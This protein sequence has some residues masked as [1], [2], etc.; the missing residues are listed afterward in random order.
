VAR[1]RSVQ[2]SIFLSVSLLLTGVLLAFS[3]AVYD[4]VS[5]V[6]R[7]RFADTLTSLS[8]SVQANLD[9]KVQAMDRLS[10]SLVYSR[11][12][13]DLYMRHLALPRQ[14]GTVELRIAKLEN[15]EAIIEICDTILGPNQSVPQ[16]NVF[17]LRGEMIGAGY[18][19][20]LIERDVR[21]EPWFP[22]VEAGQGELLMLPPRADPLLEDTSVIVKGKLYVSLIRLFRDDMRS[23]QGVIEVKQYC[24]SL[25]GELDK[26]SSP[27]LSIFVVDASGALLYPYSGIQPGGDEGRL[28]LALAGKQAPSRTVTGRLPGKR[29]TQ[30]IAAALSGETGWTLAI[31]ENAAGLSASMLQY[32]ARIALLAL[33]AIL[34]SL[35]ASY[36]IARRITVP[37]K[38][39][40]VEMDGL[41]LENLD[42]VAEGLPDRSLGEIDSLRLAF[43]GMKQKLNES[44]Q[45]AVSLKAHEKQAQLAALQAQLNPHFIHNMLQTIAIMAEDGEKAAIQELIADL[46]KVLRYASSTEEAQATLGT[47][48]EYAECY[49]AAMRLRFGGSFSY[50]I[51]VD[52]AMRG[53]P[54][55]KLV[56][57]PFIENSFKY[58]TAG[59]PP[60]RIGISGRVEGKRW[61]I[62]IS[63]NG[64]GFSPGA[65]EAVN[66][67]LAQ[68]DARG[69][70]L[71]PLSISGMGIANS[72]ER[73]RLFYGELSSFEIGNGAEG[74]ALVSMGAEL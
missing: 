28:V 20:R 53:I 37:L 34:C 15:T 25:F 51:R 9:A 7:A 59:R 41:D 44:I 65:L 30:I 57:Q 13:Q 55:P 14:P 4:Y 67:K 35:A 42:R 70:G 26:L 56:L 58:A 2:G 23:T 33:A 8:R 29:D 31:G 73:F 63:D 1:Y 72:R 6:A 64:P 69:K 43:H 46:A 52:G 38:S 12:F 45:E 71:P 21:A 3:L 49:L 5:A 54:V 17:D 48:L 18:Y 36:L 16:L 10:L 32:A 40:H 19:S 50:D 27:S 24:D 66:R 39:L 11:V 74:G 61:R 22:E 62:E 68:G 47:E 60:W